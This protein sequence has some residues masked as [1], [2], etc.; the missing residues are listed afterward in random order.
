MYSVFVFDYSISKFWYNHFMNEQ[1]EG[2]SQLEE[3]HGKASDA[4]KKR[5]QSP[6]ITP[7]I[8]SKRAIAEG[9]AEQS[10]NTPLNDRPPK[11]MTQETWEKMKQEMAAIEAVEAIVDAKKKGTNPILAGT[12]ALLKSASEAGLSNDKTLKAVDSILPVSTK[13][14]TPLPHAKPAK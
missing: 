7:E 4:S 12:D 11:G 14:A 5:L 9:E 1:G 8:L 2:E 6:A 3:F 13:T 10:D